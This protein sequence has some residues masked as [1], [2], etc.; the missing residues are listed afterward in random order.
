MNFLS[1]IALGSVTHRIIVPMVI[2]MTTDGRRLVVAVKQG[3]ATSVWLYRIVGGN[4]RKV[5]PSRAPRQVGALAMAPDGRCLAGTLLG[6]V[7]S[8]LPYLP[9]IRVRTGRV[10]NSTAELALAGDGKTYALRVTDAALI[11]TVDTTVYAGLCAP[12]QPTVETASA[13][14]GSSP[15]TD[16]VYVAF[17]KEIWTFDGSGEASVSRKFGTVVKG[18]DVNG[19]TY[20]VKAVRVVRLRT[21]A[22]VAGDTDGTLSFG[23]FERGV[24]KPTGRASKLAESIGRGTYL[25]EAGTGRGSWWRVP[26]RARSGGC[27]SLADGGSG[28]RKR[29]TRRAMLTSC[30]SPT[31]EKRVPAFPKGL[32]MMRPRTAPAADGSPLVPSIGDA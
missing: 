13:Y 3:F 19:E 23:R 10:S 5:G 8:I 16:A 29:C 17:R 4:I 6:Q 26:G 32:A 27:R 12:G 20:P 21:G 14:S 22:W 15:F 7:A 11:D 18:H 1:L 9:P 25:R 24:W 31:E 28:R 2:G 30:P